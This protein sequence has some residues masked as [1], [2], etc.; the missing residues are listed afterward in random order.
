MLLSQSGQSDRVVIFGVGTSNDSY[1]V[2]TH[3]TNSLAE[4]NIVYKFDRRLGLELSM[5]YLANSFA[6]VSRCL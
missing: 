4:F 2:S 5:P 1:I 6:V 3:S